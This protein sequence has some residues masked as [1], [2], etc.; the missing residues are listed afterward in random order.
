VA[1][2]AVGGAPR[3]GRPRAHQGSSASEVAIFDA[4]ARLLATEGLHEISVAHIL[5]ESGVSRATF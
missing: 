3:D 4:T 1:D 2:D 5:R